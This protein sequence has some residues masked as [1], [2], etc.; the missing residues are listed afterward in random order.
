MKV[1][2]TAPLAERLGG[3]E[4]MLW[5]LLRHIDRERVQPFVV[6]FHDG[7]LREEV[8]ELG[9]PTA[10]IRTGRLREI[11]RAPFAIVALA[12]LLR[13]KRPDILLNWMAKSQLYGAP[14]ALLSGFTHRT[15]WWQHGISHLNWMD[16]LATLLPARAVACSSAAAAHAQQQLRPRRQTFVVHPGIEPPRKDTLEVPSGLDVPES[17]FLIGIVGRL[18]PDKGQDRVVEAI[19]I[20]RARGCDVHGLVVGGNAWNL[21]P[22]YEPRLHALVNQLGL[23]T[24]VTFTGQVADARVLIASLDALVNASVTEGCPLV[25]LEAMAVGTPIVAS[26]DSGGPAE[27]IEHNRSGLLSPSRDPSDLADELERL[28]TSAELCRQLAEGGRRRFL[29]AFTAHEMAH[30]FQRSLEEL[31]GLSP[32]FE[33]RP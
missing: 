16:R 24:D 22:E 19:H 27:V 32:S 12:Q 3:A 28:V 29:D 17:R 9:I 1:V 4:N 2:I 30:T 20:L 7:P 5:T 15:I 31:L 18:Q 6:F 21:A 14:A 13:R 23:D 33:A 8:A 25:L 11:W 26:A 10:V